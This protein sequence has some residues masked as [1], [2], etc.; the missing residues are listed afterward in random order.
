MRFEERILIDKRLLSEIDAAYRTLETRLETVKAAVH[1]AGLECT[2]GWYNGHYARDGR[3]EFLR[4]AYPIPVV[5]VEK[6][7]DIELGFLSLNITAKLSRT[8]ALAFPYETLLPCSFEAYGVED[9]LSD[10]YRAGQCLEALRKN[11]ASSDEVE[12]GFAF[13]LPVAI[14]PDVLA[15][16]LTFLKDSRFFY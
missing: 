4:Q 7:C 15:D 6:L 11:V 9:Y 10:C 1:Q 8:Q 16:F 3:G 2:S 13:S 14:A 5:S 12:I